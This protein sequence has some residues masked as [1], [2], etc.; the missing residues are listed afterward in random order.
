LITGYGADVVTT[1]QPDVVTTEQPDVVTTEQPVA[2]R[3]DGPLHVPVTQPDHT[4]PLGS[5]GAAGKALECSGDPY[6]GST[7]DNFGVI[8]GHGSAV[9]ALESFVGDEA[10]L[11]PG[12]GYRAEREEQGRV[13]FSYDVDGKTK[14]AIIVA[15]ER[16]DFMGE[17][18]W[19]METFAQCDPAEFP[20]A[21][22]DELGIQVWV[23][24]KGER[25]PTT[26]L[27][28]ARGPA[29][30]EWDSATFLTFN[31]DTYVK[32]PQGVL[33][34]EWFNIAFDADTTLPHD[35]NETGYRLDRH[36]LWLAPD[37]SAAYIVTQEGV[38]RWPAATDFV[39]CG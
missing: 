22:T 35:A 28:S 3:Y 26:V 5:S 29:H 24:N 1:E 30:C 8:G 37:R 2:D 7:G 10:A 6:S 39:G 36:E 31:G 38:E 4:D 34:A 21:V 18:G 15:D 19:S 32:D 17:T 11:G 14:V 33:P 27:Q 25:V 9:D 20:K 13:L 16:T 12:R 23:D